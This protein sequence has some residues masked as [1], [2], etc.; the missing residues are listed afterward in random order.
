MLKK[1]KYKLTIFTPTYNRGYV[2]H[3]LKE[4][5]C[6][7]DRFDFEWLIIDDGSTDDTEQIISGWIEEHLPF[8]INYYKVNN[9]GKPRAIN[10]A[11]ELAQSEWLFMI[12]SDDSLVCNFVGFIE[13]AIDSIESDSTF[14]GVGVLRGHKNGI[15]FGKALFDDYID[16]T[17]VQRSKY[18]LNFDCNEA[19]RVEVLRQY[20]FE[21]WHGENFVPEEVVLNEMSLHG[22]KLRWYNKVGVISEYLPDGMTIGAWKLIKNNPMG[23]AMMYNHRLKYVQEYKKRINYIC[24]FISYCIISGNSWYIRKCNS[25]YYGLFLPLGWLLSIRRRFQFRKIV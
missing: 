21:V 13:D 24:Q 10:L 1:R 16:A 11:C 19:Y 22:Y 3:L 5:L 20:P 14:V 8:D 18:G 2:L 25:K 23:Y 17:N 12:D 6:H 4:S 7:Q 9:G 15:P